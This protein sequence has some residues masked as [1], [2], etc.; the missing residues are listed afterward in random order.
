MGASIERIAVGALV[1]SVAVLTIVGL[2]AIW[3]WIDS[4][5]LWKSF[6][7]IGVL[8]ATALIVVAVSRFAHFGHTPVQAPVVEAASWR[9]ARNLI[10]GVMATVFLFFA[11]LS[12]AAIWD[13]VGD[14]ALSRAFGSMTLL[15][16]SA[17][18]TLAAF[19]SQHMQM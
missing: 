2:M 4:D 1:F 5:A 12:I 17:T 8:G 6:S 15:F 11:G 19:K 13:F 16:A 10:L 14:D 7:T 9:I 18:I 3:E